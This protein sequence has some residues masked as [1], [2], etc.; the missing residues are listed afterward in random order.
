[1]NCLAGK[2]KHMFNVSE[3]NKTEANID[4]T[5]TLFDA[6]SQT[7]SN[8]NV[9]NTNSETWGNW[10]WRHSSQIAKGSAALA[11]LVVLGTVGYL[12]RGWFR[13]SAN[14]AAGCTDEYG[15][16]G[17]LQTLSN[18][19]GTAHIP[20]DIS[21]VDASMGL[22]KL[23]HAHGAANNILHTSY[24]PANTAPTLIANQLSIHQ[25]QSIILS[26]GNLDI[27]DPDDLGGTGLIRALTGHTDGVNSVAFS[28]AG[29]DLI[30]SVSKD[31]TIKVW[32]ATSGVLLRTLTGHT[33]AV[34]S[35]AFN[36]AGDKIVSGSAD[37]NTIRIWNTADGSLLKT[38]NELA[39]CVV[40]SPTEDK[41]VSGGDG[42]RIWNAADGSLIRTIATTDYVPSLALNPTGDKIISGSIGNYASIWNVAD[43]SLVR[44]LAGHTG[45][46]RSVAINLAGDKIASGSEDRSIKIWNMNDGALLRTLTGHTSDVSGIA[47]SQAGDKIAS[48]SSDKSIRIWNIADG[49]LLRVLTVGTQIPSVVFNHAGDQI[50]SGCGDN[51][52]RLWTAHILASF[53]ITASNIQHGYFDKISA[54]GISITNFVFQEIRDNQIRFVHDGSATSPGYDIAVSNGVTST[55]ATAAAIIFN[56]TPTLTANQLSVVQGQTVVL[57]TANL[58]AS[59]SEQGAANLTFTVSNVQQGQFERL[60]LLGTAITT[61]T[62]QEVQN[63]QIR[64]VHNA[65]AVAPSYQVS[66][67]DGTT[68]TAAVAATVAFND[69]PTLTANQLSVSQGQTVILTTANLNASDQEQTAAQLIF[70]VSDVQCGQFKVSGANVT[71]FTL[72]QV[73]SGAVSFVH[74]GSTTAP[75]YQVLVSDGTSSTAAVAATVT[76]NLP[77]ALLRNTLTISEGASVLITENN[78]NAT[79]DSVGSTSITFIISALQHGYFERVAAAR[80]IVNDFTMQ[81]IGDRQI[82]FAHDGSEFPPAYNVTVSDGLASS[83]SYAAVIDFTHLPPALGTNQLIINEGGSIILTAANLNATD[84]GSLPSAILFKINNLQHGNFSRITIPE[85]AAGNFTMQ[86]VLNGQIR[87]MHDCSE[88]APKYAVIASDNFASAPAAN[89]TIHFNNIPPVLINNRLT[90]NEG[91]NIL[92]SSESI[93]ALNTGIARSTLV[94]KVDNVENGIFARVDSSAAISEFQQGEIFSRQIQFKHIAGLGRA[95][96]TVTVTNAKQQSV[97]PY[98][99]DIHFNFAP[100]LHRNTLTINPNETL[101]LNSRN[102][103]ATDVETPYPDLRFIMSDIVNGRFT[104][105][106]AASNIAE[107][108]INNFTQLQLINS[109]IRFTHNGSQAGPFYKVAVDDGLMITTPIAAAINFNISQPTP[110]PTNTPISAAGAVGITIGS[111]VLVAAGVG[112]PVF[113][114][115]KKRKQTTLST[116]DVDMEHIDFDNLKL[117]KKIGRG[118]SGDV[119]LGSWQGAPVAVKVVNDLKNLSDELAAEFSKELA[120]MKRL[121]HP[122]V[123]QL[124]GGKVDLTNAKSYLVMEFMPL[125]SLT[126]VLAKRQ[127]YPLPWVN[128]M[129]IMLETAL[130]I[131]YLHNFHPPIIHRDVKSLNFLIS[132]NGKLKISDFGASK[133]TQSVQEN[134]ATC[135]A[136]AT[137]LWAAP[138]VLRSEA[139]TAQSDIFSLGVVF[140]EILTRR[141]PFSD[142]PVQNVMRIAMQISNNGKREVIP[143]WTPI[144]LVTLIRSMWLDNPDKRPDST[145][146]VDCLTQHQNEPL[147]AI[148]NP[149]D[150]AKLKKEQPDLF[151]AA[152]GSFVAAAAGAEIVRASRTVKK[153]K[154][155][156]SAMEMQIMP[157]NPLSQDPS[158]I[159]SSTFFAGTKSSQITPTPSIATSPDF[160]AFK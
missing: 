122:N 84:K 24:S 67:S 53:T 151:F 115:W 78:F 3:I 77:P 44:N 57:T 71:S 134:T 140:W 91:D 114:A 29:D 38:I 120:I 75:S 42:I 52:V 144:F 99:A 25:N 92:L 21:Y 131:R 90:L 26:T 10:L 109:L 142:D 129:Q 5:I 56:A 8:P 110:T 22:L 103:N 108:V 155:K 127:I 117:V 135:G 14:I 58:N 137:P 121:R 50:V 87:F 11:G 36:I 157:N 61:F 27:T 93:Y 39:M 153:K 45:V 80:Q 107:I 15:K 119:F 46:V 82:Y 152:R 49:S 41:V 65:S 1:M 63:S 79:D 149:E 139:N 28:I 148:G 123:V 98:I 30:A 9:I 48:G 73:I 88:D 118:G 100:R 112:I 145:F 59:D 124:F 101:V 160:R 37:D 16:N 143:A 158:L 47:F 94:F 130:G 116:A 18:A 76:F 31:N 96:Y 72:Q 33:N 81:Y 4:P 159:N 32:N 106:N 111:L 97:G 54:S 17:D 19:L 125:G 13:K 6:E 66:V 55:T 104:L 74:D 86:E 68:S 128:R 62:L 23:E 51:S 141:L 150:I 113:L 133:V 7:M 70:T 85:I 136:V 147:Q 105:A 69:I 89:A 132:D 12:A 64:F 43:G 146:V 34:Y 35:V 83:T 40:F 126:D 20:T 156:G 95:N 2:G 102:L 138:E 154:G 60:S